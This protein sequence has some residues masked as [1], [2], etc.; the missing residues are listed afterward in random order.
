MFDNLQALFELAGFRIF[1]IS[2]ISRSSTWFWNRFRCSRNGCRFMKLVGTGHDRF[3][4]QRH[5]DRCLSWN[6]RRFIR[7]KFVTCPRSAT[8]WLRRWWNWSQQVI[9]KQGWNY[10]DQGSW[11]E[12]ARSGA[13]AESVSRR[14]SPSLKCSNMNLLRNVGQILKDSWNDFRLRA[15]FHGQNFMIKISHLTKSSIQIS[16][17]W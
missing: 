17:I 9:L 6:S 4:C 8:A 12:D 1:R 3:F 16:N 15:R 5:T 10:F 11:D 2:R 13:E 14:P 7:N